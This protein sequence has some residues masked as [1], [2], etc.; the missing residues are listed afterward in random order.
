MAVTGRAIQRTTLPRTRLQERPSRRGHKNGPVPPSLACEEN[1]KKGARC[2]R[3]RAWECRTPSRWHTLGALSH[4][5]G[6]LG[7]HLDFV[8]LQRKV[9]VGTG[10]QGPELDAARHIEGQG[11]QLVC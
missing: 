10:G 7:R 11:G 1:R 5:L 4:L 2:S 9:G 6:A 3:W 8:R